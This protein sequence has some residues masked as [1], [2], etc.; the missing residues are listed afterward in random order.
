MLCLGNRERSENRL[1]RASTE[2]SAAV[3]VDGPFSKLQAYMTLPVSEYSLLDSSVI[4]RVSETA[5]RLQVRYRGYRNKGKQH[6]SGV[7][8]AGVVGICF[9]RLSIRYLREINVPIEI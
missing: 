4:R 5:F 1:L 6:D 8:R 3:V 9:G 2:A 7:E